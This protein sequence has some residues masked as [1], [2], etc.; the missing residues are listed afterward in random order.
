MWLRWAAAPAAAGQWWRRRGGWRREGGRWLVEGGV[1]R[2]TH[3]DNGP[4][5]GVARRVGSKEYLGAATTG[6]AALRTTRTHTN[7]PRFASVLTIRVARCW[8]A[9][10]HIHSI[11]EDQIYLCP[12][13]HLF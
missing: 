11:Q 8:A 3:L 12:M 1:H 5:G 2:R 13:A 7:T 4:A 9:L 10:T 6:G